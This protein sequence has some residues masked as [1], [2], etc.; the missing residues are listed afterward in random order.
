M[1]RVEIQD[2][3]NASV[4]RLEGRLAGEW[5]DGVRTAVTHCNQERKLVVDLREVTFIDAAGEEV[6]LFLRRLAAEF[7]ADTSYTLDICERLHLPVA[8]D[9][10]P[11]RHV[12]DGSNGDGA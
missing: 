6:L 2:S 4:I 3:G 8:R 1:L 11:K 7:I 5:V 12:A 9:G 10:K